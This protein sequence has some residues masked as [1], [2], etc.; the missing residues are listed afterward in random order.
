MIVINDVKYEHC[1]YEV[2]YGNYLN[3]SEQKKETG[4]SPVIYFYLE[5]GDMIEI[6]TIYDIQWIKKMMNHKQQDIT[7]Y[8]SDFLYRCD[9]KCSFLIDG[10]YHCDLSKNEDNTY[11]LNMECN[12]EQFY[13]KIDEKIKMEHE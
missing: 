13:I 1:K 5:N 3:S 11:Q 12:T 9:G 7:K 10:K 4:V 2:N 6:E 8:I